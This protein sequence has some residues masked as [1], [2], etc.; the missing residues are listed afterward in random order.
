M[1]RAGTVAVVVFVLG[2][3]VAA[4]QPSGVVTPAQIAQVDEIFAAYAAPGSPG[5]AVSVTRGGAL[6][7][8]KGYGTA[9]LEQGSAITP[10]T[11]FYVASVSK[12]F[13]G[14]S[15]GLLI[16]R[17]VVSLDDP[18]RRWVPELPEVA[19]GVSVRHLVHHT[20]G[21]RD[22]LALQGVA[23]YPADQPLTEREFL[24]LMSRQKG[25]VFPPGSAHLY[26]NSGYVLL[27]IIIGRATSSS[28]ASFAA[29]EVFAPLGMRGSRFR[30]DH[31]AIV[32]GRAI[33]Y[34]PAGDQFRQ[35]VP[36]FD[37]VGDGGLFS[38][39]RELARW[40]P[41][42]LP[43]ALGGPA[44]TA[45][46]TAPGALNDGT[47]VPYGLG[48][49]I[50]TYR[51][52]P[53]VRHGGS[54]GGYQTDLTRFPGRRLGVTVLCN[55]SVAPAWQWGNGGLA[56][57]VA[58]VFFADQFTAPPPRPVAPTP[59]AQPSSTRP[60]PTVPQSPA[61]RVTLFSEELDTSWAVSVWP[62]TARVVKRN[63]VEVLL[64]RGPD[65]NTFTGPG[66]TIRLR[67][68]GAGAITGMTADAGAITGLTFVRVPGQYH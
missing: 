21:V 9:N 59:P 54:Y 64:S 52:L 5:C 20:G 32:P 57:R 65:G 43:A 62:D 19:A 17:G 23:G 31:N 41:T 33:G 6:V 2:A 18:V 36:A 7:F 1:G 3:M 40:D 27:A 49:R 11:M 24:A 12:Q 61:E 22:Y 4:Q 66:L 8:A 44:A 26:S 53:I 29:R 68:D 13:T 30:D 50:D 47:T 14:V 42:D 28:L 15:L 10:D 37:V 39:A 55:L 67:R 58:D 56:Q 16:Q 35:D 51:G 25:L 48:V 45:L 63:Q 46:I 38:S 34:A 60:R